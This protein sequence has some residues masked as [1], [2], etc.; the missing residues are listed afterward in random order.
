MAILITGGAGYI[1]SH[2][3][4]Y[5]KQRG[6]EVI[7]LDNLQ[8]GNRDAV[9]DAKFYLGDLKD[10]VLLDE[11]FSTN[12]IDAVIHFAA[13]SLVGESVEKPLEYYDN[14]V[15]GSFHLIKKMI[16]HK[17]VKMVFSSTAATYG[18]PVRVPITEE[19]PTV[20]TNPY[21]DTKL[22]IEKM[23][24]WADD[25]YGLKSACLR[26]FN[27]A[28]ADPEGRIGEDHTPES[29][30]IPIVLQ[31]ALGQ[32]DKVAIFGDDYQTEDGTCIRDYIH[33]L[34]LA[35][36]HYLALKR[37][38][39]TGESGIYNLGNGTGFS[40]K[41]VIDTCCKV[42]NK[43]IRAEVVPRRAGDPAVLI[44]SSAKAN[45]VLGWVPKYPELEVIVKHAWNWHRC[46]V[47][48][49]KK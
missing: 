44:A 42:T 27:A 14:N 24:K 7:V 21:G 22:A 30:L 33:V 16:E 29:H 3:V 10:E 47:N 17:V 37:L 32:R 5:L 20:P 49:Y 11:I 19:D 35:D 6:E 40:V 28:G 39:E 1:G 26:Y 13:N 23:L 25:A 18:N 34:D 9:M 31:V 4:L 45:E 8:K 2:T 12:Q 43:E 41:Q 46:N 15:I 38:T 36:A 48:G